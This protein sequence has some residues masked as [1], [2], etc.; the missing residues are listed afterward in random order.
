MGLISE[1]FRKRIAMRRV[2]PFGCTDATPRLYSGRSSCLNGANVVLHWDVD[3][4]GSDTAAYVTQ[5]LET[6]DQVFSYLMGLSAACGATSIIIAVAESASLLNKAVL[7]SAR[8]AIAEVQMDSVVMKPQH[9]W[10]LHYYSMLHGFA[11]CANTVV[12]CNTAQ[13][14]IP[15]NLHTSLR[16]FLSG[17]LAPLERQVVHLFE[18]D[19]EIVL[20]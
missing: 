9:P 11:E 7:F 4:R 6:V 8:D 16:I 18:G 15:F 2:K 1:P 19:A 10:G 14:K 12:P 17:A 3:C 5:Q 13:G 20:A